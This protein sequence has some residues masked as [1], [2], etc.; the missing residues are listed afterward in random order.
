MRVRVKLPQGA[1]I[2]RDRLVTAIRAALGGSNEPIWHLNPVPAIAQLEES[3]YEAGTT[4]IA[5]AW[6]E[7]AHLLG[8]PVEVGQPVMKSTARLDLGAGTLKDRVRAAFFG[9]E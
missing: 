9:K 6:E 5:R 4:D 7:T 8:L 3:L 2:D 1:Q